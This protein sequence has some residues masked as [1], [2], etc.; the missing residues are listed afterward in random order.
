MTTR[1]LPWWLLTLTV[2]AAIA[3]L[4]ARPLFELTAAALDELPAAASGVPW[5]VVGNTL[6]VAT[7]VA[8]VATLLGAGAAVLTERVAIPSQRWLRLGI[9]IPLLVPPFV[10]ALSWLRAYG[11]GGLS[12]DVLDISLPGISGPFGIVLVVAVNAMPLAY[13]VT[14]AALN[15]R[16]KPELE[17]A[18]RISGASG[19]TATRT[20]TLPL[21]R[22]AL[23]GVGGLTFVMG[24][25]AFGVPAVLG[26][27]AGYEVVTT[28]IYQDLALS[29]RPEAFSRATL[30]AT[31][32]VAV[33]FLFVAGAEVLLRGVGERHPSAGQA[34]RLERRSGPRG[35]LGVGAWSFVALVTIAPLGALVLTALTSGVGVP[36]LPSNWTTRH[37]AEALQPRLLT[38]G[39]RSIVLAVAAATL[40]VVLGGAVAALRRRRIGRVANIAV[41]L[42]FAVPG[43]TLAVAVLLA[44]GP[45]LRNTLAL[46]LVAYVAKLWAVSHRS[47]AGSADN[48]PG[49]LF[50]AAR[51]SGATAPTAFRTTTL[52]LLRPA[53]VGAWALVFLIAVHELTMSSLL[54][55]P[56]TETLAVSI[57]NV[58]QLGDV[59]LAAALAVILTL[60]LLVV[61][62][63]LLVVG[64]LPRRL[65]G[66]G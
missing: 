35:W 26:T 58:T 27:P 55:G 47:I 41:M 37:F 36:Q 65:L 23:V 24:I 51:A 43:S 5:R 1:R 28:Q 22:R 66:T 7:A 12:D 20:V 4:V 46:I 52:P 6:V 17:A 11:P 16:A 29:A 49:E 62:V 10:S 2:V 63:P 56:G 50:L 33:A 14:V 39:L 42:T 59:P 45:A 31:G 15:T 8:L 18:A 64:R 61:A 21:L 38:A 44:Y 13:L 54:Y 25:N 40:A 19:A 53:L 30:L 60:P 3:A 32:L 48:L 9:M 57:L 34:L